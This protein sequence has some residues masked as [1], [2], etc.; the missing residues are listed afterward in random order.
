MLFVF[1]GDARGDDDDDSCGEEEGGEDK[2]GEEWEEWVSGEVCG[3]GHF[4]I[5]WWFVGWILR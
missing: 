2:E 4:G 3:C 5:D 1:L